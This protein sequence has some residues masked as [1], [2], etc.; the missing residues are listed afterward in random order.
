MNT[1]RRIGG[2]IVR[3]HREWDAIARDPTPIPAVL[4]TLLLLSLLPTIA[5]MIGLAVFNSDWS[6]IHGYRPIG[7]PAVVGG[8]NYASTVLTIVMLAAIFH[9]LAVSPGKRRKPFVQSLNVAVYGAVP[10]LLGGAL[11]VL[12]VMVIA[13][14]VAGLHSLVLYNEG[15]QRVLEVK[16]GESTMLVAMCVVVLSVGAAIVGAVASM[17]GLL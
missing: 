8:I 14:L 3:P 15:I 1:L 2:I 10:A 9:W 5:V 12:P 11:L 13:Q 4:A 16:S 7:P 17:I 6:P